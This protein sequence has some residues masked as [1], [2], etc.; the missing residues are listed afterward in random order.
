[1]IEQSNIQTKYNELNKQYANQ[2]IGDYDAF[3]RSRVIE[4]FLNNSQ[5]SADNI[6]ELVEYALA[7]DSVSFSTDM[8]N[9]DD[10]Y[11]EQE[12]SPSM[13]TASD[14]TFPKKSLKMHFPFSLST[15]VIAGF[16]T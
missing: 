11:D 4:F 5:S 2:H 6:A 9:N 15:T 10:T 7:D 8:Q 16:F 1:M 13:N 12:H 14:D 3:V